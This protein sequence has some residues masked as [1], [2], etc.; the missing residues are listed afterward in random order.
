MSTS[1]RI[2]KAYLQLPGFY[3]NSIRNTRQWIQNWRVKLFYPKCKAEV[4]AR[5]RERLAMGGVVTSTCSCG[6]CRLVSEDAPRL[7]TV[8]HCSVCRNDEA[9]AIG[10]ENAPAPSFAAVRRSSCR[11]EIN[12]DIAKEEDVLVFRNSSDFARRG[13]CVLCNSPLLMD[14]EWFEPETVWLTNPQWIYKGKDG[15]EVV[16]QIEKEF[17]LNGGLADID[18]CWNSRLDPCTAITKVSYLG[19][20]D[21]REEKEDEGGEQIKERG[22]VQSQDLDW[23]E[24]KLD[25]GSVSK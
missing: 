22:K 6:A 15:H 1:T 14:Y 8:C 12:M 9:E 17:Y 20:E 10:A 5:I 11:M 7:V 13:R 3:G 24:Y 21:V 23:T 16:E 2:D 25:A 18:V 4:V 19:K